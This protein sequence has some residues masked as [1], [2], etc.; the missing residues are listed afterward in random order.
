MNY[1]LEYHKNLNKSHILPNFIKG[2]QSGI[3]SQFLSDIFISLLLYNEDIIINDIKISEVPAFYA[4]TASGITLSVL[5]IYLDPFAL[6]LFSTISYA[7]VFNLIDSNINNKEF[8]ITPRE[9]IFDTIISII[10]IYSFD[11]TAKNQ[12]LRYQE[13]RH[14]IEPHYQRMDRNN[15][16]A[17][18]F[19]V[20]VSTYNYLKQANSS[21]L[22]WINAFYII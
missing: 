13:K 18:F 15:A 22:E 4:A 6:V 1:N 19:I 10:L 5:S 12:F 16:Q 17:I 8:N 14:Y 3:T 2:A 7:F 20:L 11:P 21:I 9:I